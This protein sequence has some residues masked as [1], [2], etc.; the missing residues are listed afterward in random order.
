MAPHLTNILGLPALTTLGVASES[1]ASSVVDDLH[2][3][4]F[5]AGTNL[6]DLL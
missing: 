2:R 3:G 5:V 4:L 1:D 6:T